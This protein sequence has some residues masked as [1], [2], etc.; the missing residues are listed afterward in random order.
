MPKILFIQPTQ[1][2]ND[3][4]LCKQK[5]I[6]LPG[7][8]FPLLASYTPSHWEVEAQIEVVDEINYDTDA[9]L[10]GI[11]TMGH[12]MFRGMKIAE[13]FKKK[14]KTVVMGGYMA[15]IAY[16]KAKEY[17]DAV[18]IGDAE[19]SYREML[20]DFERRRELKPYYHQPVN[21]LDHL[22]GWTLL[23]ASL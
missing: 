1:Y 22:P 5:S 3:G 7:L 17:C 6:N 14:G 11:G 21:N 9:D 8:A 15:S 23:P 16:E 18:V 2:A 19:F 4:Q 20:W 12:A 10:I 13:E